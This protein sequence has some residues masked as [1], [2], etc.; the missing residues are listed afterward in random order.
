MPISPYR[1]SGAGEV[2]WP[3][4]L[5][6]TPGFSLATPTLY[7]CARPSLAAVTH[8]FPTLQSAL[9]FLE[10]SSTAFL[11][12]HAWP[13]RGDLGISEVDPCPQVK[14]KASLG[15]GACGTRTVAHLLTLGPPGRHF[16]F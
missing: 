12:K 15:R 8:R 9:G 14:Q 1:Q 7:M 5:A 13:E 4:Q 11:T 2:P 10:L 3:D 6:G 16:R